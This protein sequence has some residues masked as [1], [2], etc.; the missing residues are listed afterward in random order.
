MAGATVGGASANGHVPGGLDLMPQPSDASL[1]F[2]AARAK[3]GD[4][5]GELVRRYAQLVYTVGCRVTDGDPQ[6]GERVARLCLGELADAP[7]RVR[8][9]LAAWLHNRAVHVA[10]HGLAGAATGANGRTHATDPA[11][12][13]A[14]RDPAEEPRWDELRH[15]LDPA[16]DRLPHR[17]RHVI[18]QHYL[19]RHSQ[20][21]LAEMLQVTQPVVA[22]RLRAAL[23]KLRGELVRAGVGCSLA[24]LMMLLARHGASEAPPALI[25]ELASDASARLATSPARRPRWLAALGLWSVIGGMIAAVAM[26]YSSSPPAG[27]LSTAPND[28]SPATTQPA[29][30]PTTP[31]AAAK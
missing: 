27:A 14:T 18:I 24:H 31:S 11:D 9:E 15:A 28:A 29:K 21:E 8:G 5:M 22:R 26:S 10:T 17:H 16:L 6:A 13:R 4:A 1:V 25:E 7:H 23:E 12:A 3:D 30:P 20:D 19:Q 2:A